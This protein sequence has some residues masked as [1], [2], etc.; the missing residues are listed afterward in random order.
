MLVGQRSLYTNLLDPLKKETNTNRGRSLIKIDERNSLLCHRYFYY[1][2]HKEYK[3][4][5][6]LQ[7]LEKEFFITELTII[8]CLSEKQPVLKKIFTDKPT[9]NILKKKYDW[10]VWS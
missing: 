4:Q 6:A 10:L 1:A 8:K 7:Q 5:K 2:Y 9:V 3:Y